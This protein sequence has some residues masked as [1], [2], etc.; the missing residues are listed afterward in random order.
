MASLEPELTRRPAA[1]TLVTFAMPFTVTCRACD[2]PH[3][4][5]TRFCAQKS[6]WRVAAADGFVTW[7]YDMPCSACDAL[8]E[9]YTVPAGFAV[10][11][12]AAGVTAEPA[13]SDSPSLGAIPRV[14]VRR[15]QGDLQ[16][17]ESRRV[18]APKRSRP[19]ALT[20]TAVKDAELERGLRENEWKY[21]SGAAEAAEALA[22]QHAIRW[23]ETPL[24]D[25]ARNAVAVPLA[26]RRAG[27]RMRRESTT[28]ARASSLRSFGPLAAQRSQTGRMNGEQ[29]RSAR[30]AVRKLHRGGALHYL[31]A[32]TTAASRG[33]LGSH[34]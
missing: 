28:S 5:G 32:N 3:S 6:V 30:Q 24:R 17:C 18:P 9:L 33:A 21:G 25:E 16:V 34:I 26:S 7:A 8:L 1:K 20:R 12:F 29:Y 2:T 15:R 23:D 14:Q 19:G 4:Q 31:L 22:S 11:K 13:T 27:R 10:A